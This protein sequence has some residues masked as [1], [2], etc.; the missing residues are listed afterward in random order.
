MR[1][2]G[3]KPLLRYVTEALGFIDRKDVI[4]V[5]GYKRNQYRVHSPVIILPCRR[6]GWERAM[7]LWRQV[8]GRF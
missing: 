6:S 4:I 5:V 2:A 7:L 1:Q 8:I 3:G